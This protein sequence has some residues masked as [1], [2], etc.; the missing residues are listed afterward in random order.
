MTSHQFSANKHAVGYDFKTALK[1]IIAPT[2]LTFLYSIF[3]FIAQPLY[4]FSDYITMNSINYVKLRRNIALALTSADTELFEGWIF[5]GLGILFALFSFGF[6]TRKKSVNVFFSS[7]VDRRTL[8]KNRVSASLVMMFAAIII[9]IIFDVIIN[10]HLVGH[11]GYVIGCAAALLAECFVYTAAGF[12]IMS[13]AITFC[14]TI[15]EGTFLCGT[16]L[17]AP[18]IAVYLIDTLCRGF[19]EGYNHQSLSLFYTDENIFVQ[20]S[21]F[22]YT[23]IINPL[24]LGKAYGAEYRISDNIINFCYRF[25]E[26]S[27]TFGAYSY[28]YYDSYRGYEKITFDYILPI[29]IWAVFCCIMLV[30]ARQLFIKLKAENVGIHGTRPVAARMFAAVVSIALFALFAG[31][32]TDIK[33]IALCLVIMVI[34]YLVIMSVCKRTVKHKAKELIAPISSAAVIC[35][36][37]VVFSTGGF[38]YS[39]YVPEVD[40]ID[41]A[42][43]TCDSTN[44]ATNEIL[45]D[46]SVDGFCG[47]V[48]R[49]YPE[50]NILGIFTDSEDLKQFTDIN[51]KLVEKTDNMSGNYVNV[52]YKLKNGK[53]VSRYYDETD[54]DACYSILSLRDSKAVREE[55]TYLLCGNVKDRP[56]TQKLENTIIN[57][58]SD[59]YASDEVGI[60]QL[61]AKGKIYI[62]NADNIS[63]YKEI[64]NTPQFRKALLDDLLSQSYEDRF[65]PS[66]TAVGGIFF[67]NDYA[68]NTEDDEYL[69][70]SMSIGYYIYPSM[71][72]TINYLKS[73][74]EYKLFASDDE[75]EYVSV[76]SCKNIGIIES[77]TY[78]WNPSFYSHQFIS[79]NQT[80]DL[81]TYYDEYDEGLKNLTDYFEKSRKLED[82]EQIS[83]LVKNARIY[84]YTDN[85]DY[86]VLVKYKKAG[87]VTKLIPASEIPQWMINKS[88]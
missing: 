47:E 1:N 3:I 65:K 50:N 9:P 42:I 57:S 6:I 34:V 13:I 77:Q 68:Y 58:A 70:A 30:I 51:K 22:R 88:A 35:L 44:I 81:K 76:E 49:Y 27:G 2:V 63:T 7:S 61:Y 11:A 83:E 69:P 25:S 84:Y 16:I 31:G 60:A 79:A 71:T 40:E 67:G 86:V 33:K 54:F 72:N 19:L 23:S 78:G 64:K 18:S 73:T 14:N 29:I 82:K 37:I 28:G 59:F 10:I 75:I 17:G 38:G 15:I 20:P 66:E 74:G 41:S 45:F 46:P 56:L 85:N 26:S 21:L 87:Y 5:I 12:A 55:L 24:L 39:T 48:F 36:L 62:V 32:Y 43:I 4:V 80:S 53:T 8:Y 52:Y